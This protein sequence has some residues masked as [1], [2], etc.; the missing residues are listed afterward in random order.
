MPSAPHTIHGTLERSVELAVPPSR[1]FATLSELELRRRWF[2]IP[3]DDAD[4]IHELDFRVGGTEL[5]SGSFT[6]FDRTE[7]LEFRV[8]FVDIVVDRRVISTFE[9]RLD[10]RL[11]ALFVQ[12]FELNPVEHDDTIATRLDYTDHYTFIDPPGD[13]AAD[14]AERQGSALLMLIGIK[15][16]AEGSADSA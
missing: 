10:D 12:T 14:V 1:V 6:A 16:V 8:R 3:G 15:V 4:G 2:R 9:F 5:V 13:G 7:V 11:R